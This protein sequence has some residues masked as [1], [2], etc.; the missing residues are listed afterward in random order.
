[1]ERT[2]GLDE[3]DTI[4]T[5]L[6][7]AKVMLSDLSVNTS[8]SSDRVMI[9]NTI[10]ELSNVQA[11]LTRGMDPFCISKPVRRMDRNANDRRNSLQAFNILSGMARLEKAFSGYK[12]LRMLPGAQGV[13]VALDYQCTHRFKCT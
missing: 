4:G 11:D 1:M 7:M 5:L 12:R 8:R 6:E 10:D 3:S 2:L 9:S 13:P